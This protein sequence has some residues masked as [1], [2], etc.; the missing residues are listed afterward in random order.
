MKLWRIIIAVLVL[1]VLGAYGAVS[2]MMAKGL[3]TVARTAQV[4]SPEN[5]KLAY[6][7]V[8]FPARTDHLKLSGWYISQ[9]RNKKTIISVA[10]IGS[11]RSHL[12]RVSLAARLLDKGFNSL[13]FDLRGTGS[14]DGTFASGGYFEQN[15]VLG[16]FDFASQQAVAPQCI[17]LLGASMG[18][19]ATILAA[20]HEPAITAVVDDSS[21]AAIADLIVSETVKKSPL[22]SSIIPLF[23]PGMKLAA[24]LY[25]HIDLSSLKPEEA[26]TK[27]AYP[28]LIIHGLN[29]QRI[30]VA[31]G[32][33]IAA[34]APAGSELWLVPDAE[35]ANAY[36]H[37]PETYTNKVAAYFNSRFATQ[38][39]CQ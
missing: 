13:L 2:F 32:Q 20:A 12:Q 21:Y 18:G 25:Y 38:K 8:T 31:Q 36:A 17:G 14:S 19:A 6:Q 11:T 22:P 26:V 34:A 27:L 10:G 23:V 7:D 15:D 39:A 28:L 29:D 5:Y 1:V 4:D 33:R 9:P 30:P 3:T 37:Q 16:A 24:Q 35:H